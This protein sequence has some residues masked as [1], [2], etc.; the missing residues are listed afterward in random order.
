MKKWIALL[1]ALVMCLSL[2]A[3]GGGNTGR[4]D[5]TKTID[6]IIDDLEDAGVPNESMREVEI[7]DLEILKRQTN[8]DAMQDIIYV[9]IDGRSDTALFVRS[10]R[11][12][13]KL[14]NEGWILDSFEEYSEGKHATKPSDTPDQSIIDEYFETY[15]SET[16]EHNRQYEQY[17]YNMLSISNPAYSSW[18]IYSEEID[19]EHGSGLYIVEAHRDLPMCTTNEEIHIPVSFADSGE[20][21]VDTYGNA[22]DDMPTMIQCIIL[23]WGKITEY[24]QFS[25]G[26]SSFQAYDFDI[27][28]NRLSFMYYNDSEGELF[29][30]SCKLKYEYD[31]SD[32]QSVLP[33]L[34]IQ[35]SDYN[36]RQ[37]E[38]ENMDS[39]FNPMSA[40]SLDLFAI[41]GGNYHDTNAE[42]NPV[43]AGF[44]ANIYDFRLTQSSI[45]FYNTR[46]N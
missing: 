12:D 6:Q 18:E 19:L 5:T 11:L 15:N 9:T 23:D 20:W 17:G 7:T 46:F 37:Q 26:T 31:L 33:K 14:Y 10:Y 2:C 27:A 40:A 41:A 28:S 43:K 22:T 45:V 42:E 25:N 4:E 21:Y 3:C 30:G 39:S 35:I 24:G 34:L 38:N 13:Y 29:D 8:V 1:L 36:K 44:I 16:A 32:Y